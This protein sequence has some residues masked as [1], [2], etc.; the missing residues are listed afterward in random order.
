[1]MAFPGTP[2]L[3]EDELA[4]DC[5]AEILGQGKNSLLYKNLVK[6]QKS[7]FATAPKSSLRIIW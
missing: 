5:V 2:R 7:R 6:T 1:M 3:S 4:L